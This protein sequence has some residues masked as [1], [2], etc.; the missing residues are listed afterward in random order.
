M[1]FECIKLKINWHFQIK[2]KLKWKNKWK[3]PLQG[4]VKGLHA[5]KKGR[6]WMWNNKK[7]FKLL[8]SSRD[9]RMKKVRIMKFKWILIF[10]LLQ[11]YHLYILI[12]RLAQKQTL[13]DYNSN[14]INSLD[15]LRKDFYRKFP[16]WMSW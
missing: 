10:Q 14:L 12:V 16:I 9:K 3:T 8:K 1:N 15:M 11:H 6:K 5:L 2:N 13:I 4:E 7:A